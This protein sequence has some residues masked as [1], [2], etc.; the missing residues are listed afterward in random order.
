MFHGVGDTYITTAYTSEPNVHKY[1]VGII[2]LGNRPVFIFDSMDSF[3]DERKILAVVRILLAIRF[4]ALS[5]AEVASS[6][7]RQSRYAPGRSIFERTY[8]GWVHVR[9]QLS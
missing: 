4:L 7:K 9:D 1:I 8:W 5:L 6:D 2:D 3:K